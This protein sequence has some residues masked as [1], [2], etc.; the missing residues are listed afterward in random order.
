MKKLKKKEK[1]MLMVLGVVAFI[2]AISLYF[3][4]KPDKTKPEVIS[5]SKQDITKDKKKKQ[6]KSYSANTGGGG[7]RSHSSGKTTKSAG[8]S[9]SEFQKHTQAKD[10]WVLMDGEVYNITGFINKYPDYKNGVIEFCGTVGFKVGFLKEN[11]IR[12]T[13]KNV[14]QKMGVIG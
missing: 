13:I 14:S 12:D 5:E 6:P 1:K 3:I 9:M 10:C 2:A 11:K 4:Y 7:Q 8:I